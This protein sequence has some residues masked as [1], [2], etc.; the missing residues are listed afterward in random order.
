[1]DDAIIVEGYDQ[2]PDSGPIGDKAEPSRLDVAVGPHVSRA[3]EGHFIG[4]PA[5]HVLNVRFGGPAGMNLRDDICVFKGGLH[6]ATDER[7]RDRESRDRDP[8]S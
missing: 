6:R 5:E 8:Q 2:R 4:W 3:W 1:L 7:Q